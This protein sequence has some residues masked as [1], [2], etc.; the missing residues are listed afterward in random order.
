MTYTYNPIGMVVLSSLNPDYDIQRWKQAKPH[1]M[2]FTQNTFHLAKRCLNEIPEL[3]VAILRTVLDGDGEK[4]LHTS[5]A[6]GA[7]DMVNAF[8]RLCDHEGLDRN[9]CY[10]QLWNEP[11]LNVY[12]E[13]KLSWTVY[14]MWL[15]RE[16]G[17]RVSALGVGMATLTHTDWTSGDFDLLLTEFTDEYHLLNIHSYGGPVLWAGAAGR[18]PDTYLDKHLA[19]Q[20]NAPSP[21]DVQIG[22]RTGN[23]HIGRMFDILTQCDNLGIAYPRIIV[24]ECGIDRMQDLEWVELFNGQWV[25]IYDTLER[26]YTRDEEHDGK[27]VTL[28][29]PWPHWGIR[30]WKTCRW[31]HEDYYPDWTPARTYVEMLKW[32]VWVYDNLTSGGKPHVE[33]IQV[34]AHCPGMSDWDVAHGFDISDS[35][36]WYALVT[37]YGETILNPPVD[38]PPEDPPL[39]LP[40]APPWLLPLFIIIGIAVGLA[41]FVSILAPRFTASAMESN[42]MEGIMSIQEAGNLL[43]GMIA[44]VIAGGA[45]APIFT[46]L[47]NLFKFV[48]KSIGWEE[49][50]TGQTINAWV[51]GAIVIVAFFSEYWGVELQAQSVMDWVTMAIPLVMTGIALFTGNKYM[52]QYAQKVDLPLWKYKRS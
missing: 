42:T 36:E 34:F 8:I 7:E 10:L 2:T 9:R 41:V 27:T 30:G 51:A 47:V 1:A 52:Y 3:Q 5:G 45:A 14:A 44:A 15:A 39:V 19:Q 24:G 6:R 50:I 49:K 21:Y 18:L 35:S 4:N 16:R 22:S 48:L 12:R 11:D 17:V 46:P 13:E 37:D 20:E 26:R 29:V 23:W 43:V 33:A 25:N 32:Q 40:D 31:I 38:P 28:K